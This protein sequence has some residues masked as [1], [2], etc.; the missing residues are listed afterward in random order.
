MLIFEPSHRIIDRH[1]FSFTHH[2][3]KD[4][5]IFH[6]KPKFPDFKGWS[7]R[8]SSHRNST[9]SYAKF[10]YMTCSDLLPKL[11]NVLL[12]LST[13]TNTVLGQHHGHCQCHLE[14]KDTHS[15]FKEM[16]SRYS[17]WIFTLFSSQI[18]ISSMWLWEFKEGFSSRLFSLL[19]S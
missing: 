8:F 15:A 4:S 6:R 12:L 11:R 2:L 17:V 13:Y 16:S 14:W 19:L 10:G 7:L 9:I 18:R 1:S 5:I 3:Q